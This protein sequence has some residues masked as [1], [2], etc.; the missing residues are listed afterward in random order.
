MATIYFILYLPTQFRY[1]NYN[2]NYIT[3]GPIPQTAQ[4]K[5]L[6]ID[7]FIPYYPNII[8]QHRTVMPLAPI[9]DI[10]PLK[11]ID[12]KASNWDALVHRN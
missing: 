5:I 8:L 11:I 3:M 12:K 4:I 6:Y 1:L 2:Y 7:E 9:L 10:N